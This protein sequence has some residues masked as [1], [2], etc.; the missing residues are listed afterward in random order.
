M[1]PTIQSGMHPDADTLTAFV[2]Q[3]LP[4]DE[5]EQVL[6]HMS[7]CTRCREVAFLAQHA[8]EAEPATLAVPACAP[9]QKTHG[10]WLGGWR[11]AWVPA[12]VFAV[13][14]GV[15]TG[16]Y[17][18][19]GKT[20]TQMARN[21]AESHSFKQ[22]PPGQGSAAETTMPQGVL[23][24]ASV[25]RENAALKAKKEKGVTQKNDMATGAGAPAIAVQRRRAGGSIHGAVIARRQGTSLDGPIED[26][27]QP[28]EKQQNLMQ[29]YAQPQQNLSESRQNPNESLGVNGVISGLAPASASTTVTA[30]PAEAKAKPVP[31]ASAP[32]PVELSY[33]PGSGGSFELSSAATML[34][35]TVAK[36]P[37]PSGVPAL[38]VASGAGR[39]I[40]I[41]TSGALFL[42]EGQDSEDQDRH[43]T[44]V[45][46]QW[47]GRAVRVRNLQA[48]TN[49]AA[50]QALPVT[51]F[52]L[53][54]D[55]LQIWA[56][57][58]GKTWMAE[59]PTVK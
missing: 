3:L 27:L 34:L 44:R 30:E 49:D 58:D 6:A 57:A 40:A 31:A 37:L 45:A 41:D 43:W 15:V 13:L 32:P 11:W 16:L 20:D 7:T 38:S 53:V 33:A 35:K 56:S 23:S 46:T 17:F 21:S 51:R 26:Q 2:E 42:S 4:A 9:A 47:T 29:Q 5:R 52:E 10:W 22:A 14:V 8:A 19:H 55:K 1:N 28:S 12:G 18:L 36:I 24:N 39:T 50:Q 25:Q 59:S 54:N 48:G